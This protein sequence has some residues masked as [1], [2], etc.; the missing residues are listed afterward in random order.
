MWLTPHGKTTCG[1]T[2]A[3]G[4]VI[5][6]K[7]NLEGNIICHAHD[8][9]ILDT[10]FYDV[11]F[12]NGNVTALTA[13]AIAKTMYAQCNP[14]SNEYILLDE[15]IVFNCME[16]ALT[17][18]KQ[19]ITVCVNTCQHKFTKGLFNYCRWKDGSTS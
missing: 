10:L 6:H 11:Q 12:E 8:N 4:T 13:N 18:D 9:P 7:Y 15:L 5:S 3:W 16:D 14:D 1:N 19:Q 17:L 2:F